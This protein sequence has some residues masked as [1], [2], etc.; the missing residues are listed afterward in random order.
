ML[1]DES[2]STSKPLFQVVFKRSTC[3]GNLTDFQTSFVVSI[4]QWTMFKPP[5]APFSQP[6]QGGNIVLLLK[7]SPSVKWD[8]IAEQNI[9]SQSWQL[10]LSLHRIDVCGKRDNT[11]ARF[12]QHKVLDTF[13]PFFCPEDYIHHWNTSPSKFH[14]EFIEL[15]V[16]LK[17]MHSWSMMV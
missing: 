1:L 3:Q 9:L 6:F 11:I 13:L 2:V 16:I 4:W 12:L 7:A 8:R 5:I 17:L 10:R 14:G 15:N